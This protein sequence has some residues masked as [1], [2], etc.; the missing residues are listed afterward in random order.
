MKTAEPE[1]RNRRLTEK[2][3][4]TLP[5]PEKGNR[6]YFDDV[7][8]GFGIRVTASGTKAFV[9]DYRVN[10]RR[11]RLTIGRYP[12]WNAT[13]A[14]ERAKKLKLQVDRGRDPLGEKEETRT[15]STF[16]DVAAEYLERHAS[17]KKSGFRDKEYLTRDVLPS[18]GNRKAVDIKRRDVLEL[19]ERKAEQAPIS[20][21]RLL[22][23]IR[24]VFNWAISRDLLDTNPCSQVPA[25]AIE[26]RRDRVLT[27]TEIAAFWEGLDRAPMRG[28]VRTALRLILVTSQRPGEIC[29]LE[30]AD[31]NGD[32]WTVAAA[33]AKNGLS[34]RVPLSALAQEQLQPRREAT[35]RWLFP[36]PRGNTPIRVNALSVPLRNNNHFGLER[37]TPH[38]LRRTAATMMASMGTDRLTLSKILN[39]VE[40][41]VTS[42]YDRAT[43][44]GP[45]KAAL[46]KWE[47]KLRGVI[48]APAAAKVVVEFSR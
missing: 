15:A 34:H 48:G 44:D 8:G 31:L 20:A 18:W 14:R 17:K 11:R 28:E 26:K 19:I 22:A 3:I 13:A 45:K 39:H 12:S 30:L 46:T 35:E 23:C 25:P 4:R 29:E 7:V 43:Y 5:A 47:R 32:W 41:G 42:V 16:T 1:P 24:K 10:R 38:D 21:N 40:T 36:S 33:K 6:I 9:F 2:E 27:E 37:F